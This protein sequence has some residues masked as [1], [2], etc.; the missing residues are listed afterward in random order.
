VL[1][2]L[3]YRSIFVGNRRRD[4]HLDIGMGRIVPNAHFF[5]SFDVTHDL[6]NP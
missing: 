3:E 2:G 5:G 4:V 1:S 6:T